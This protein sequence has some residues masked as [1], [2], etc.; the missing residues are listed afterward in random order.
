MN[1]VLFDL[2]GTLL[3][4]NLDEFTETYIKALGAKMEELGYDSKKIVD[5]LWV[6][7][8]AM[9]ENDGYLTNEECFWKAFEMHMCPEEKK[10]PPKQRVKLE[11][12]LLKFYKNDFA[13]A[14]FNTRPTALAKECVDLLKKK[15]YY[16]VIATNPIFPEVATLQRLAW[17][18]IDEEDYMLVTTYENSCFTKPNLGYYRRVLQTIDKDPEDC[19]MV[20]NDV[21]EDMCAF[22]LGIDVFLLDEC[23]INEH[24]EG[25]LEYKRGGWEEFKQFVEGLPSLV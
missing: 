12:A 13:V 7:V 19:L 5:S 17:A 16:I 18:G 9:Y 11:R 10:M 20:G 15:G 3:P 6:G 4:M 23:I 24:N 8:K 22:K 2:D 25:T 1:T 21:H 14:R